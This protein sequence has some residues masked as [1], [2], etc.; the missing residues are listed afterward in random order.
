MSTKHLKL[1]VEPEIAAIGFL[2]VPFVCF[3][4]PVLVVRQFAQVGATG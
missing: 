1:E 4:V 3:V 2:F